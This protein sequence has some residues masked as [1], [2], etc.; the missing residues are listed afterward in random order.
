ME[1]SISEAKLSAQLQEES[2]QAIKSKPI[3][4]QSVLNRGFKKPSVIAIQQGKA[5]LMMEDMINRA[6]RKLEEMKRKNQAATASD[7]EKAEI[8]A[9]ELY[10][11]P[12]TLLSEEE[13]A[14]MYLESECIDKRRLEVSCNSIPTVNLFRQIDGTCNNIENPLQ[15]ASDTKLRR[16]TPPAYEDGIGELRG[17]RQ[18]RLGL[19]DATIVD[20][21]RAPNPSARTISSTII[22]DRRDF[23]EPFSHLLMQFGQFLDHDLDLSPE[24]E[25]EC[26]D[27]ELTEQC[28]PIRVDPLDRIFGAGTPNQA[29][30]LP[31]RRA[32]AVCDSGNERVFEPREQINVLTSYIDA[33]MVYGSNEIQGRAVRAFENGLLKVGERTTEG[34]RESLP[35]DDEEPEIVACP[36]RDPRDCFLCGDVR[37]N[38]QVSLSIMHTLWLREHNRIARE[39][40]AL[41]PFWSDEIIY[42]EA[43]KIVGAIIQKIV[44][45][46]YLPIV[47]GQENFDR[48]IGEYNGYKEDVDA[49]VPNAFATAAYRYGHSLIRPRFLRLNDRFGNAQSPLRLENMF[50]NPSLYFESDGVGQVARGWVSVPSRR[51]DEFMNIVLTRNL[52]ENNAFFGPIG[53]DLASLNLQRA[54]DHGLATYSTWKYF[55]ETTFPELEFAEINNPVTATR[56]NRL[57]GSVLNSELFTTGLAEVRRSDSLIGPT[58]VCLFGITFQDARDGDRFYFE[59]AGVFTEEQRNAIGQTSFSRV[60]CDNTDTTS[61]QENSFITGGQRVSCDSSSLIPTLNLEPWR[62]SVCFLP[63][64]APGNIQIAAFSSREDVPRYKLFTNRDTAASECLPVV[65]PGQSTISVLAFAAP[66]FRDCRP[67]GSLLGPYTFF[68]TQIRQSDVSETIQGCQSASPVITFTCSANAVAA[69]TDASDNPESTYYKGGIPDEVAKKIKEQYD[70]QQAASQAASYSEFSASMKNKVKNVNHQSKT[71]DEN[72]DVLSELQEILDKLS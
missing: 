57:H 16:L 13:I 29:N 49:S 34:G 72:D 2:I 44:Y 47:L 46:D 28:V 5:R 70:Q 18:S 6:E 24:L 62:E 45:Y 10:H 48:V 69:S 42:Q 53:M 59:N 27:C 4:F 41:N 26:E 1:E 67:S 68:S 14:K 9:D 8:L 21:F 61:I 35:I 52:F 56:L 50:F 51:V 19:D 31:F 43:R 25:V 17:L 64:Q 3:S 30:C 37:C 54:R 36:G 40:Q 22:R 71:V 20:P 65:C 58:F 11:R 12:G 63:I 39:L 23:E 66:N 38:E 32:I 33:S 15:G 60:I 55:C 7:E